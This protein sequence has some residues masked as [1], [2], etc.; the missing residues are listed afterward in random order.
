MIT[1]ATPIGAA[2]VA[3]LDSR[4]VN[5][6][7]VPQR[8]PFR[9]PGGKTWLVPQIRLWL[10]ACRQPIRRL[11]EPFAGGGIVSLTAVMEGFVE[12]AVLVERDPNVAAV[13]QVMV[14]DDAEWLAA[15]IEDLDFT[16][17]TVRSLLARDPD[18][19]RDRALQTI[20]RNRVSRGGILAPGAGIVKRGEN[21]RGLSSRWYPTTLARRI[22][23]IG[24]V[25]HRLTVACDDGM[26]YIARY[27]NDSETAFFIDP[28][29][30]VAGRRLYAVNCIDHERLFDMVSAVSGDY[31]LTYDDSIAIE[32]LATKH[33]MAIRRTP[34][35][36]THHDAKLEMLIGRDLGWLDP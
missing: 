36:T 21:G 4:I 13:W 35:K 24:S 8:S 27:R 14:D 10:A 28:P 18:S 11:V 6:A 3:S 5:V 29:Y 26:D 25:R 12:E 9:Y 15:A 34:M 23:A 20:I 31:L 16:E 22:R 7:S 19:L 33:N 17:L 2:A 30:P 1:P 32:L